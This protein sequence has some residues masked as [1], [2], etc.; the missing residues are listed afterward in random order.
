MLRLMRA[1]KRQQKIQFKLAIENQINL[2]YYSFCKGIAWSFR[3]TS[4]KKKK[5]AIVKRTFNISEWLQKLKLSEYEDN[6]KCFEAVE[7][8]LGYDERDL[9]QLGIKNA[10]HRSKIIASF[11]ALKGKSMY[12]FR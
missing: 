1:I 6:F 3:F 2:I 4:Q 8:L 5:N 9:K 7:E 11:S 10:L 12:S